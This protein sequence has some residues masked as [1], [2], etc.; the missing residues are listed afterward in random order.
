MEEAFRR[1]ALAGLAVLIILFCIFSLYLFLILPQREAVAFSIVNLDEVG[2]S[3]FDYSNL[4]EKF[5]ETAFLENYT[6]TQL[7]VYNRYLEIVPKS[8]PDVVIT[9]WRHEDLDFYFITEGYMLTGAFGQMESYQELKNEMRNEQIAVLEHIDRTDFADGLEID[10]YS[11]AGEPR[12]GFVLAFF[13]LAAFIILLMFMMAFRQGWLL[14][15][16]KLIFS[17]I[18]L[19]FGV[20][21]LYFSIGFGLVCAWVTFTGTGPDETLICW[22]LPAAQLIVGTY[23]I[24]AETKALAQ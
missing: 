13:S 10:D 14:A 17:N 22:A 3:P 2:Q 21:S 4:Q 18:P 7:N 5:N 19:F 20:V 1:K 9:L 11:F 24:V 6:V 23:L 15:N 8:N 16:L 12:Y